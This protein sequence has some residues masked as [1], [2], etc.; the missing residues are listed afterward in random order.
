MT[1]NTTLAAG[2]NVMPGQRGSLTIT[3]NSTAK[4]LAYNSAFYKFAGAATATLS[5]ATAAGT[6]DVLDYYIMDST[7]AAC[8]LRNGV[9]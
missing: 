3:Q 2:T 8:V 7:S 9:A 4:I 1:V 6:R 5:T